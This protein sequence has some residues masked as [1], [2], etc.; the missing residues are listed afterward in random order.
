MVELDDILKRQCDSHEEIDDSLRAYL[1]LLESC[2]GTWIVLSREFLPAYPIF[3]TQN[4]HVDDF[5]DLDHDITRCTE[6]V[7]SSP[8]FTKNADYIRLQIIYSLLQVYKYI[9]SLLV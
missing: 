6:L 9:R 7:L 5:F 2:R 1:S 3:L 4:S 8:L